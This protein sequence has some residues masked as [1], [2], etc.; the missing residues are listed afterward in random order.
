MLPRSGAPNTSRRAAGPTSSRARSDYAC[1]AIC[2][3]NRPWAARFNQ[4]CCPLSARHDRRFAITITKLALNA[5]NDSV[6]L[7][8]FTCNMKQSRRGKRQAFSCLT[9]TAPH[10]IGVTRTQLHRLCARRVAIFAMRAQ[11]PTRSFARLDHLRL[12][13][14]SGWSNPSTFEH[15]TRSTTRERFGV[16][17]GSRIREREFL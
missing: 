5:T 8:L 7:W 11:D 12:L 15:R 4:R 10:M 6:T 17:A 14:G 2:L 1:R 13:F 3:I 16:R 9:S